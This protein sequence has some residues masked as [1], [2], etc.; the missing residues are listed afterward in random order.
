MGTLDYGLAEATS[1]F[2]HGCVINLVSRKRRPYSL[3]QWWG[4]GTEVRVAGAGAPGWV[5][6]LQAKTLQKALLGSVAS[7]VAPASGT[8]AAPLASYPQDVQLCPPVPEVC[9]PLLSQPLSVNA[10]PLLLPWRTPWNLGQPRN[11]HPQ[12]WALNSPCLGI[13]HSLIARSY[14][15]STEINAL[16]TRGFGSES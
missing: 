1:C 2:Q 4:P 8:R 14:H 11:I 7:R 9:P 10:A 3:R 16:P 5:Q 15:T 13:L 12:P 6:H